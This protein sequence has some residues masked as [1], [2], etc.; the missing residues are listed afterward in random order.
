MCGVLCATGVGS[1]ES[2]SLWTGFTQTPRHIA[3]DVA[4]E[5]SPPPS[6]ASIE[7]SRWDLGHFAEQYGDVIAVERVLAPLMKGMHHD[8]Y[9][10]GNVPTLY[11]MLDQDVP[12]EINLYNSSPIED[13]RRVV[14]WIQ[15]HRPRYVVLDRRVGETSDY[16]PDSVRVPFLYQE[17]VNHYGYVRSVG[18]FDIL[19]R[20]AP[21]SSSFWRSRLGGT[22]ALGSVIESMPQS[23]PT[24]AS[25]E[26][27]LLRVT[28]ADPSGAPVMIPLAFGG[29]REAVSFTTEPGR[30]NYEVPLNRLW[31]WA[32]SSRV[33]VLTPPPGV[34]ATLLANSVPPSDLY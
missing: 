20:T 6:L 21:R 29:V 8:L 22:I 24:V 19:E 26:P 32:I 4:T 28:V 33:R 7:A 13:Q 11:L 16:I 30:Q 9:V 23:P 5:L 1:G 27:S 3:S 17:V 15:S 10:L 2:S 31:M 25:S 12:W 14:A 18:S 34:R